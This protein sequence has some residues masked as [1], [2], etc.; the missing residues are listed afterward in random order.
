MSKSVNGGPVITKGAN[1]AFR[2]GTVATVIAPP[3]TGCPACSPRATRL[4][5]WRLIIDMKYRRKI[6]IC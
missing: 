1:I 5:R 2:I 6:R 4:T 3:S